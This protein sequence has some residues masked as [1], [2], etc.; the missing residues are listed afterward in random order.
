M[1]YVGSIPSFHTH[2]R[3]WRMWVPFPVSTPTCGRAEDWRP[4]LLSYGQLQ[5]FY[6]VYCAHFTAEN[7]TDVTRVSLDFRLLPGC[8]YE[9]EPER[10]PRDFRVGEYYSE[11][12]WQVQSQYI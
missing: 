1:A 12:R 5:T 10:Q 8:C 4:L 11:C 2:L 9:E 3:L 6:G 7:T